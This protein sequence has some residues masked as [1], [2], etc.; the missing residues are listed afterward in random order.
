MRY[1]SAKEVGQL[2]Y[3]IQFDLYG[4]HH[5][6]VKS[7]VIRNKSN[8]PLLTDMANAILERDD[9]NYILEYYNEILRKNISLEDFKAYGETMRFHPLLHKCILQL[10]SADD[11][12]DLYMLF[13]GRKDSYWEELIAKGMHPCR[14]MQWCMT[15][16]EKEG[17]SHIPAYIFT[18]GRAEWDIE[19]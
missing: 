8:L 5:I 17:F 13:R 14:V 3:S 12:N 9:S 11:K 19:L 10:G 7:A 15:E 1:G 6:N 18:D 16:D 4:P 2:K